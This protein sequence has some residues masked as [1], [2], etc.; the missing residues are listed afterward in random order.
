M[1]LLIPIFLQKKF[2]EKIINHIILL[3]IFYKYTW[4]FFFNK[5]Q[6][7]IGMLQLH[8]SYRQAATGW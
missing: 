7:K 5:Y 1:F 6:G 4:I 2:I 3:N 8:I